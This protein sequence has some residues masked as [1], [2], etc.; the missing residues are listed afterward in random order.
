MYNRP[1]DAKATAF[2]DQEVERLLL[3]GAV[4]KVTQDEVTVVSPLGVVPKKNDKL[5]LILD[6]RYVNSFVT[7]PRFRLEDLSTLA[8]MVKQGDYFT[9]ID[10]QSGYHHLSILPEHQRF[11][12]FRWRGQLMVFTVLPFGLNAAPWAFDKLLRPVTAAL[13]RNTRCL[14]YLDDL[15]TLARGPVEALAVRRRVLRVLRRLGLFV[16]FAKSQL[17][18]ST[19]VE[20]LG[21]RV[22]SRPKPMLKVPKDKLRGVRR[23]VDRTLAMA[24]AARGQV[25]ARWLARVAGTCA[26][27][28]KAVMPTLLMLR[29]VFR[30]IKSAASY[31]ANVTLTGEARRDLLWWRSAM[32]KWSGR[33]LL[34]AATQAT[35]E[36][37][38][39]DTGWG[40]RL[41]EHQAAGWWSPA[42]RRASINMRELQAIELGL[43]TFKSLLKGKVVRVAT[44]SFTCAC[45]INS[46]GG[47]VPSLDRAVRRLFDTTFA[48]GITL[49]A[50]WLPGTQNHIPDWLSR[51]P[52]VEEW[53][54][55][56][57]LFRFLDQ[58]WGPHSIDRFASHNNTCLPRFTSRFHDPASEGADALS[59]EWAPEENNWVVPPWRLL[60][61][62]LRHIKR[63]RAWAT[64]IAPVWPAQPWYPLL[65]RMAVAAVTL[66]PGK[67]AFLPPPCGG[68][69]E[70]QRNP[71]WR[72]KAWR[73]FGGRA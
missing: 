63:Q 46:L 66:P 56:K 14:L 21:L 41:G 33:T 4:R 29:S 18:P 58:L 49:T 3:E 32:Q 16:N 73:V 54:T 27:L 64:I 2:V 52:E 24:E 22:C 65:E 69:P 20:Y 59:M 28:T 45:F 5:R 67:Q 26:A 51:L 10:L 68:L 62:T 53:S 44:D 57:T 31:E 35:L 8:P 25:K 12:G 7:P 43:L 39:S 30:C 6:L 13:R 38:A 23:M 50:E 72:V 60:G 48:L 17:T 42:E 37:D 15:I 55:C 47:R 11:L 19:E 71:R 40:A 1:M 36:T 70:P 9:T 61:D 34:P